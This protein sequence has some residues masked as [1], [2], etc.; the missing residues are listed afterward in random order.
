MRPVEAPDPGAYCAGKPEPAYGSGMDK[1]GISHIARVLRGEGSSGQPSLARGF[2]LGQWLVRPDLCTLESAGRSIQLEPKTMGVLLCLAQHVPQVVTREQF[3]AEVWNGRVVTDEVLSRAISLLR[4]QLGDDS[5][6]PRFVRT[7]PRVGYALIAKVE[8]TEPQPSAARKPTLRR[9]PIVAAVLVLASALVAVWLL[10]DRGD[11]A[12]GLVRLAVLPLSSSGGSASDATLADGLTEELTI[13]LSRVKGIRVVARNSALRFRSDKADLAEVAEALRATHVMTGSVHESNGKLRINLHLADSATGSEIWAETYNRGFG[14]LFGVQADISAAVAEALRR[15]L[16]QAG[17]G[18]AAFAT[19]MAEA[20]PANP[21]TY[22]LYLQGRQQLARRGE[23]GLRAAIGLF[24]QS[25][26][27]DPAFLRAQL[28]LAWA[29][30]L[31]ANVAP[32]ETSEAIAC[33]DRALAAV[34]RETAMLGEVGAVR[35]WL[36]LEKNRWVEAESA[37]REALAA[38]PDDT[39]MRLLYSQM[40][41]ALGNP[42]AA[43]REAEAALANDPLSPTV[44]LRQAVLRLWANDD[45]EASALLA[46]AR[47]LDLAPS[48][49][50]ELPMLLLVR[51]HQYE[52][53]ERALR[54]VQHRRGQADDWVGPTVAALR[55]P[56]Q[57]AAAE[58]AMEQAMT[59][60][61]I[62]SLL[63]FG[64]LVLVGRDQRALQWLLDRPRLR[65]RELEFALASREAERLRHLPE[66]SRVLTRFGIDGY[67][68]RFGW[69]AQCAREGES[70]RCS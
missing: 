69:P 55:N 25:I 52:S 57:G 10:R 6:E 30:T 36:A 45:R 21:A 1:S 46:E 20:P 7:I 60:G 59:A 56:A 49:S 61:Q 18:D 34:A 32:A 2:R 26:Q 4:L 28:G 65:T 37:F 31:L 68:D 40:R 35:A 48:A 47:K 5:H 64:A 70:I 17:S 43:S 16:P 54:D 62:D 38:T 39:E 27:A 42:A 24:E 19:I 29:C 13:S 9:W 51:Q 41:G 63:H 15:K 14:D 53:L 66:F 33:A 11:P 50:P 23:E 44:V 58:A 8:A 3:I 22:R 12:P 67:W